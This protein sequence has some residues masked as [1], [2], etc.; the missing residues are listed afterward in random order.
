[1]RMRSFSAKCKL[2]RVELVP[3]F[4]KNGTKPQ[5]MKSGFVNSKG[6]IQNEKAR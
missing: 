5:F 1:M 4:I 3:L 2:P 6:E